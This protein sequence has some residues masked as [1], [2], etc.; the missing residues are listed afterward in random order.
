MT[1]SNKIAVLADVH[2]NLYALEA[3]LFHATKKNRAE[4]IWFLGDAVGYGPEPNLCL[5]L[6]M[7][8]V[9][10]GAWVLGNHDE[11]MRYP[12]ADEQ[13]V[14]KQRP[15]LETLLTPRADQ[16]G[17]LADT[18]EA[19]KLNYELLEAFPERFN[20][21]LSRPFETRIDPEFFLV[22]GGIRNGTPTTTYTKNLWDARDEFDALAKRFPNSKPRICFAGHSHLPACFKGKLTAAGYEFEKMDLNAGM[23]LQL[24]EN[25]WLLNPGS[26]GQPRDNDWRASYMLLDCA[27]QTVTLHRVEYDLQA[28]QELMKRRGMPANLINRLAVG[29]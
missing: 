12:P 25:N 2:A 9:N 19:Y 11:A 23:K 27:D 5:G 10:P 3:V 15:T 24:D 16:I 20:F 8:H 13:L 18:Y 4:E 29:R 7:K 14:T 1:S 28:T 21:L 17:T 26:V 6:L 22:H